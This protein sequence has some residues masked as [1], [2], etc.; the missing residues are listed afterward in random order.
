VTEKLNF[1]ALFTSAS[2]VKELIN[3]TLLYFFYF[4]VLGTYIY[5]T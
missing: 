4:K 1:Y 2:S 5:I 3:V